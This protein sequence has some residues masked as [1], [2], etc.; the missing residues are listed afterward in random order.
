MNAHTMPTSEDSG[1][2][3]P[4]WTRQDDAEYNRLS[5]EM[6]EDAK[7]QFTLF[8]FSITASTAVLGFLTSTALGAGSLGLLGLPPGAFFLVPLIVLLPTSWMILNRARTRNR[9][10]GYII[11][12]F[13]YKRLRAEGIT[14]RTPLDEVRRYP[15]L[16]WETALHILER[17]NLS[18]DPPRQVHLARPLRYMTLSYFAIETLCIALAVYTSLQ[19][20]WFVFLILGLIV[21]GVL[22]L[23]YC[24]FKALMELKGRISIQGYV[25]QWLQ[26]KFGKISGAPLY[27]QQWL[28]EY[29]RRKPQSPPR[30]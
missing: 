9:K 10:V 21:I 8:T 23:S 13:D 14:D 5:T 19:A 16:P 22:L 7:T 30:P 25:E 4:A 2:L 20:S 6:T 1:K 17:T 29:N 15:F 11:I 26:L 28:E 18:A 12:C 27:L 3:S 24:R